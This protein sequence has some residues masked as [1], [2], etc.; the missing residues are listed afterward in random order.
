MAKHPLDAIAMRGDPDK[1]HAIAWFQYSGEGVESFSYLDSGF[2]SVGAV[3]K[4]MIAIVN[5]IMTLELLPG[6][7]NVSAQT[8]KDGSLALDIDYLGGTVRIQT[9]HVIAV[10]TYKEIA[11]G[12]R[13]A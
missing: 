11:E 1:G 9:R 3:N 2:K 8:F 6:I 10:G 7:S 5:S 4:R 12:L 13:H